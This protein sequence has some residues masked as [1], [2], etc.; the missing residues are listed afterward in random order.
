MILEVANGDYHY[1]PN[2]D[3]DDDAVDCHS[4]RAD[5][6]QDTEESSVSRYA[7]GS[8]DSGSDSE[9]SMEMENYQ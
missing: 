2:D 7:Y 8:I 1:D 4:F 3:D 6:E 9:D 5:S